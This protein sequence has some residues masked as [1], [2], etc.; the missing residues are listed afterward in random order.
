MSES[1]TAKV[2]RTP[3]PVNRLA[4]SVLRPGFHYEEKWESRSDDVVSEAPLPTREYPR[5]SKPED[6]LAGAKVGRFTVIG[7]AQDCP[8]WVVRCACGRYSY[9]KAKTLKRSV[10]FGAVDLMCRRCSDKAEGKKPENTAKKNLHAAALPMYIVIREILENGLTLK[11][12]N[13]AIDALNIAE[14]KSEGPEI[15]G[16]ESI[17]QRLNI[18][19]PE[20]EQ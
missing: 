18:K 1:L 13:K 9:R 7:L 19:E 14:G 10:P 11:L 4:A 12:R 15:P 2:S 8:S 20:R 5:T 16:A 3:I 17:M 6:N